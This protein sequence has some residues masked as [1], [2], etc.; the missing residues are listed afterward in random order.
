MS[1]GARCTSRGR[2]VSRYRVGETIRRNTKILFACTVNRYL[3]SK[4]PPYT[5]RFHGAFPE[6]L[7][8]VKNPRLR[9]HIH[10]ANQLCLPP[11]C[12]SNWCGLSQRCPGMKRRLGVCRWHT[13]F[14]QSFQIYAYSCNVVVIILRHFDVSLVDMNS[15]LLPPM[16]L[17]FVQSSA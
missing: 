3:G 17:L 9:C 7:C 11:K 10:G 4:E 1:C 8:R 5:D 13:T 12:P 15:V 2:V 6:S 14:L 16:H